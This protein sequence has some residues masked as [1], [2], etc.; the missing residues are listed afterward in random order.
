M[1]HDP[2]HDRMIQKHGPV[3]SIPVM[4]HEGTAFEGTDAKVGIIIG[5]LLVIVITLAISAA[6][7]VP[8]FKILQAANPPGELPSPI[9]PGRVL[10]P[11]PVLQVHPWNEYPGLLDSQLKQLNNAGTNLAGQ[12]HIPISEAI[13]NVSGHLPVRNNA[14]EGYTVPGGQGR[15]FATGLAEMPQAY[16]QVQQQAAEL[17]PAAAAATQKPNKQGP[18]IQ[19]EIRKNAKQ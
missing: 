1:S 5:S 13:N 19:G 4:G 9:A 3:E 2:Q 16:Q 14:P 6:I 15:D 18:T 12:P 7:V 11:K 10:P 17:A 8:I